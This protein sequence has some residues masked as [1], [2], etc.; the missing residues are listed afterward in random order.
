MA[1]SSNS[2]FSKGRV[3]ATLTTLQHT[4]ALVFG[5]F[6][7]VHL[8]APAVAVVAPRGETIE[9]ATK[10][11]V[12]GRV[13]YQ[14]VLTEPLV[15]Y[16]SISIHL[17]SSLAKRGLQLQRKRRTD[18]TT[19]PSSVEG[20]IIDSRSDKQ[21]QPGVKSP[22]GNSIHTITGLILLPAVAIHSYLNRIVPSS[23]SAPINSLSPSE[24]DY[25]YVTHGFLTNSKAWR[26]VTW[27]LYASLLAAGAVHVV[28]GLD[29]IAKRT[30]ARRAMK[31]TKK[32]V[33]LPLNSKREQM[34]NTDV[35][36][37]KQRAALINGAVSIA[38]AMWLAVG[39]RR[40]VM[41]DR[42]G[43]SSS[44][45]KRLDACYS[46]VWPYSML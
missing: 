26:Y 38:G 9:L 24:I 5:S 23:S 41:D 18:R 35:K 28:A 40:M 1:S 21:I 43:A 10:T 7:I 46:F 4:S 3:M 44:M 33:S 30:R 25:S 31:E 2:P 16:A 8:A 39:L 15:V 42:V 22:F 17:L 37:R 29:R 27:S 6:L 12:L 36:T 45:M 19:D 14:N 34:K 13:Y 20:Y 32:Q 11:M